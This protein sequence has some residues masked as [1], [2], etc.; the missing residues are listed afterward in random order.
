MSAREINDPLQLRESEDEGGGIDFRSAC[1][2]F[3]SVEN[4]GPPA[5]YSVASR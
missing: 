1:S 3:Q 5:Q 2:C 4:Y